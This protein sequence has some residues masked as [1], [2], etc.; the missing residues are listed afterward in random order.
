M[1]AFP[2]PSRIRITEDTKWL[3]RNT[4]FFFANLEREFNK[5]AQADSTTQTI[6]LGAKAKSSGYGSDH[7]ALWVRN[8]STDGVSVES[9]Q[10]Q[11]GIAIA[12]ER[13]AT[14]G[15]RV[16]DIR[17]TQVESTNAYA[18]NRW[19]AS[20]YDSPDCAAY[21]VG[22]KEKPPMPMMPALDV[23]M[24]YVCDQSCAAK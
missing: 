3:E 23:V 11:H 22:E 9:T 6:R 1:T 8:F 15:W 14:A 19:Y 13:L 17:P 18:M 4:N 10:I 21:I 16:V 12:N 7:G 5:Q 24:E 20:V 2:S